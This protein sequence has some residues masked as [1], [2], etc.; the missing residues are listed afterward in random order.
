MQSAGVPSTER[1]PALQSHSAESAELLRVDYQGKPCERVVIELVIKCKLDASALRSLVKVTLDCVHVCARDG[2][3]L[4]IPLNV[5]V[6]PESAECTLTGQRLTISI[7]CLGI[8]ELINLAHAQRP[9]DIGDMQLKS[10]SL[11][12][13]LD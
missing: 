12:N 3:P 8:E 5:Y 1:K 13:D 11:L 2:D 9:F 7:Q 10:Q 4:A 6:Q